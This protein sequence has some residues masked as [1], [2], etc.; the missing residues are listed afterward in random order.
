[1]KAGCGGMIVTVADA[2]S[3]ESSLWIAVTLTVDGFGAIAGAVYN[4]SAVTGPTVESPPGRSFTAH[5]TLVVAGPAPR[6]RDCWE[7]VPKTDAALGGAGGSPHTQNTA[8]GGALPRGAV[9]P[10]V[11][12]P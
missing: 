8:W 4:P 11:P 3:V 5:R 9:T 1:M 7:R 6:G 2:L 12:V 10:N